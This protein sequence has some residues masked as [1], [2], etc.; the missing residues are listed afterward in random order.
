MVKIDDETET[1]SELVSTKIAEYR[2]QAWEDMKKRSKFKKAF[3]NSE[4]RL[5]TESVYTDDVNKGVLPLL[6]DPALSGF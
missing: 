3:K 1:K 5:W 4:D 6:T 2:T